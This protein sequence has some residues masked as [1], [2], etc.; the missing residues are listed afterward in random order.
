VTA[1]G[2]LTC[3]EV[4]RVIH[5]YVFGRLAEHDAAPVRDHLRRCASCQSTVDEIGRDTAEFL[6]AA[7]LIELPEDLVDLIIGAA[8]EGREAP[9]GG[10]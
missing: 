2:A 4:A 6:A 1:A 7:G 8:V 10:L 5:A 9:G 3:E